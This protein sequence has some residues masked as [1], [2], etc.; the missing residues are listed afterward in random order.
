MLSLLYGPTLTSIH[1]Y[2]KHHSFD[3]MDFCQQ[4]SLNLKGNCY[5]GWWWSWPRCWDRRG[6]LNSPEGSSP[7]DRAESA[8]DPSAT[9]HPKSRWAASADPP[10]AWVQKIHRWEPGDQPSW[11]ADKELNSGL[12]SSHQGNGLVLVLRSSFQWPV[13]RLH[14]RGTRVASGRWLLWSRE[15]DGAR[16][17][18]EKFQ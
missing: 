9:G 8:S 14:L 4:S 17:R 6:H 11:M 12:K 7:Q 16:G 2:W 10:R 15:R 13:W 5:S 3:Y 18:R 1:A